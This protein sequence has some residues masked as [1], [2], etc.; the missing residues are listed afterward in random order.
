[1]KDYYK[2]LGIQRDATHEDIRTA[3]RRKAKECHPDTTRMD[4][5]TAEARMKDVNEAYEVLSDPAERRKHDADFALYQTVRVTVNV[6]LEEAFRGKVIQK[7]HLQDR[8]MHPYSLRVPPGV[9]SGDLVTVQISDGRKVEATIKVRR[10]RVFRRVGADLS[11]DIVVPF[12]DAYLGGKR[13]IQTIDGRIIDVDIPENTQNSRV[14]RKSG[15]GMPVFE[16][17]SVRGDLYVEVRPGQPTVGEIE[18]L[19]RTLEIM[20]RFNV[21]RGGAKE[22]LR[23]QDESRRLR[24]EVGFLKAANSQLQGLDEVRLR[25]IEELFFELGSLSTALGVDSEDHLSY[26]Q[27]KMEDIRELSGTKG[28]WR[29]ERQQ[30]PRPI[31]EMFVSGNPLFDDDATE[32]GRDRLSI[33]DLLPPSLL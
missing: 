12:E 22:I 2:I 19:D 23:L 3:Y 24:R 28:S 21:G 7:N 32:K 1:M 11:M 30:T 5:T 14:L 6:S 27:A 17:P 25:Q 29:Q 33:E 16:N 26:L 4:K 18:K 15:W 8:V 10:H 31:T 9:D 13:P 20:H